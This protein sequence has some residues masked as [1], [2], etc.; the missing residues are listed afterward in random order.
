M[1]PFEPF[2]AGNCK[3]RMTKYTFFP[4]YY[5]AEKNATW[6]T[7]TV[8]WVVA[9]CGEIHGS[10]TGN[11]ILKFNGFFLIWEKESAKLR[12]TLKS[13]KKMIRERGRQ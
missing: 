2:F 7:E 1:L 4:I 9:P 6:Y 11:R 12:K 13:H 3:K 10:L 5:L 8:N